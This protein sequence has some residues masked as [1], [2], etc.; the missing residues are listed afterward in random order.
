MQLTPEGAAFL[1]EVEQ[2]FIGLG[3]LR[4]AAHRI[5]LHGPGSLRTVGIPSVTSGAL[6]RAVTQLLA[7]HPDYFSNNGYGHHRPH[8]AEG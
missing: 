8:H 1:E 7:D 4:A 3:N 6:P 5:A 2:H